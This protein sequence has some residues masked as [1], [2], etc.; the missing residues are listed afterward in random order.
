MA[1]PVSRVNDPR[2]AA[3]QLQESQRQKQAE[4]AA[5]AAAQRNSPRSI[6]PSNNRPAT[7]IFT[8]NG[9]ETAS[10]ANPSHVPE[11]QNN[12]QNPQQA[13]NVTLDIRG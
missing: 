10:A 2:V 6:Q 4:E 3:Q 7:D 13:F 8:S 5:R 9:R 12:N 1:A 11:R